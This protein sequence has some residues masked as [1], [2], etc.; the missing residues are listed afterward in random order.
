MALPERRQNGRQHVG[1]EPVGT[2]EPQHAFELRISAGEATLEGK[3]L[4]LHPLGVFEDSVALVG[5]DEAVG[6]P[7][8]QRM[9]D[10]GLQRPQ[11]ASHG[12]LGLTQ[13]P[14]GRAER[15]RTCDCEKDSEIAPLHPTPKQNCMDIV[16]VLLMAMQKAKRNLPE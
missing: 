7:L 3:R 6:G 9:A 8:E 1:A 13:A 10:R 5:Q 15:A 2:G 11:P 16:Q 12:W 14:R 4:L